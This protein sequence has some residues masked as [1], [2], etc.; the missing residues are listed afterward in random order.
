MFYV[1]TVTIAKP[2]DWHINLSFHNV[3]DCHLNDQFY[4]FAANFLKDR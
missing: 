2:V 3:H 1:K 4:M